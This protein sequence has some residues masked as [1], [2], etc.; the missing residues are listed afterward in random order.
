MQQREA[1]RNELTIIGFLKKRGAT[2]KQ[3]MRAFQQLAPKDRD[4]MM[5]SWF[6]S[7]VVRQRA[8]EG[9]LIE[10]E[11]VEF[12]LNCISS[13][14]MDE[15]VCLESIRLYFTLDAWLQSVSKVY[16]HV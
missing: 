3:R 8:L 14:C 15:N 9:S 10:E 1:K 13:A 4:A 2:V 12:R 16:G 11:D 5:I 7:D 6:V